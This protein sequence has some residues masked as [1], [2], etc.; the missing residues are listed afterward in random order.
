MLFL[1]FFSSKGVDT[2]FFWRFSG[3]RHHTND[4]IQITSMQTQNSALVLTSWRASYTFACVLF[5]IH[6]LTLGRS[7]GG[8]SP[9]RPSTLISS[10]D[11]RYAEILYSGCLLIFFLFYKRHALKHAAILYS[12]CLLILFYFISEAYVPRGYGVSD[13]VLYLESPEEMRVLG[14]NGDPP[15]SDRPS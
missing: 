6:L 15:P 11:S 9:L 8:G 7:D 3:R 14:R 12:G 4:R 5:D 10:G 2:L 13:S 1:R